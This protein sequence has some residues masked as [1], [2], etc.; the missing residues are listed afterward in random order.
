MPIII[1]YKETNTK[2]KTKTKFLNNWIFF[3]GWVPWVDAGARGSDAT[4]L[5]WEK[6]KQKDI[7]KDKYKEKEKEKYKVSEES[8]IFSGCVPWVDAR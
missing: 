7:W 6:G 3:S 8:D 1:V 2:T 4:G 5:F